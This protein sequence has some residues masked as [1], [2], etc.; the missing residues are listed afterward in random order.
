MSKV[1]YLIIDRGVSEQGHG[2]EVVY[3]LNTT[4][5]RFLFKLIE[6][7][8]LKDSKK[9]ETNMVM[10]SENSTANISLVQ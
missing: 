9:Y 4:E 3:V 10:H 5:K 2:R 7:L 1:Y 6:T 8:Q